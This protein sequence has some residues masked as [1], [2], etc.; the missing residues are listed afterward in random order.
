MRCSGSQH[1]GFLSKLACLLGSGRVA[2]VRL[3]GRRAGAATGE[4][5]PAARLEMTCV[6]PAQGSRHHVLAENECLCGQ[7]ASQ[8]AEKFLE[9]FG[10]GY[11]FKSTPLS[12]KLVAAGQ[13]KYVQT[14]K[15][16]FIFLKKLPESVKSPVADTVIT[17]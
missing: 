7:L 3:G 4:P 12:R 2:A 5:R 16:G 11:I 15:Q 10:L 8:L 14:Q 9:T 1:L 17:K 6:R 13:L